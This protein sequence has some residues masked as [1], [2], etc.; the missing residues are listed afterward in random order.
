MLDQERGE[1][2]MES[3]L[4]G[5]SIPIPYWQSKKRKGRQMTSSPYC[6]LITGL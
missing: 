4:Y 5:D 2:V 6:L 3:D 1:E